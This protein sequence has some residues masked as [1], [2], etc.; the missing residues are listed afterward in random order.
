VKYVVNTHWHGDHVFGNHVYASAF[1]GLQI[2]ANDYTARISDLRNP[3]ILES[4]YRGARGTAFRDK[5][6]EQA[7][8]QIDDAGKPLATD[9]DRERARRSYREFVPAFE[10]EARDGRYVGP[11]LTFTAEMTIDLGGKTIVLKSIGGHTRTDTI[12]YLPQDRIVATG[13]LV[14]APVPYGINPLFDTWIDTLD[15]LIAMPVDAF[16]PGHGDVLYS[17]DYLIAQRE[18][19]RALLAQARDAV[20]A[21]I[22]LDAFKKSLDLKSYEAKFVNGDPERKWGWDNYFIDG[23]ATRAFAIA[24]GEL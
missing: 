22:K 1:P 2:V 17:R 23:A 6:K 5:L 14:I 11:N 13:D 20:A 16:V 12:V 8:K 24:N 18:L 10:A 21:G 4:F 15:Q 7:E 9:Y 19:F 3:A